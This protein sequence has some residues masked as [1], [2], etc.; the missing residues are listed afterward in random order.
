MLSCCSSRY[1][2]GVSLVFQ[3]DWA[4]SHSAAERAA[5]MSEIWRQSESSVERVETNAGF[6][7][8]LCNL[9]RKG[10]CISLL[11]IESEAEG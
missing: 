5:T 7:P 3:V 4:E 9:R 8:I 11:E 6:L 2:R 10:M 1:R